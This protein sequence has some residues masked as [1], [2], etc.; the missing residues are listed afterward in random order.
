MRAIFRD[1]AEAEGHE[2]WEADSG[3]EALIT[4]PFQAKALVRALADY[5]PRF[6]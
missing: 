1:I 2:V 4:K 3:P 6:E 5:G